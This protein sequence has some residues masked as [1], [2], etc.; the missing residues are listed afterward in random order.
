M[1]KGA[2]PQR[3]LVPLEAIERRI[4]VLRGHRVVLDRDLADLYG[5]PL[6]RL[7]EQVRRNRD[8]FPEDFTFWLTWGKGGRY[9]L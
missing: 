4:F 3:E 6:K 8:R 5:V 1:A 7:N 2:V 9:R